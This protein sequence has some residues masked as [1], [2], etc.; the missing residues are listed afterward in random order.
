VIVWD[1]TLWHEH[2][3]MSNH[4][5][6]LS[7]IIRHLHLGA[8]ITQIFNSAETGYEKPYPQ[9]FRHVLDAPDRPAAVWMIGDRVKADVAGA[10]LA[11]I[12]SILVRAH[13]HDAKY[14]CSDLPQVFAIIDTAYERLYT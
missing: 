5:P 7:A 8:Y 2:L 10:M 1:G 9:A 14:C 11:G 4:V 12:P 13:H 3:T 6:E